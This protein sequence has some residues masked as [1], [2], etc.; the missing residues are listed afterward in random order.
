V[1]R[2]DPVSGQIVARPVSR[3][4]GTRLR[5]AT[6]ALLAACP[7]GSVWL[8]VRLE[9]NPIDAAARG[10][11]LVPLLL[12]A[13]DGWA[14]GL[15]LLRRR[16]STP[17]YVPAKT[18]AILAVVHFLVWLWT[19]HL[20]SFD[21]LYHLETLGE[22]AGIYVVG[23]VPAVLLATLVTVSCAI[24]VLQARMVSWVLLSEQTAAPAASSQEEAADEPDGALGPEHVYEAQMLL[25]NLGYAVGQIDGDLGE[26]TR[27]ALVQFQIAA[28]LKQTGQVTVLTMIEL[29]NRWATQ[30][31]PQPGQ[32]ALALSG[33]LFRR[34]LAGLRAWRGS[35]G[36]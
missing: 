10:A 34:L 32:T 19:R 27:Q 14:L 3:T 9:G 33:H 6:W 22:G 16:E 21:A 20:A 8:G 35:P 30:D 18:P 23:W 15:S 36:E 17:L 2:L 29:R 5:I 28:G 13:F 1:N 11:S 24:A 7:L 4:A 25:N 12:L 31:A 26:A